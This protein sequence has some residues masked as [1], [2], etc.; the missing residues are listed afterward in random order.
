MAKLRK[1]V[2]D[3]ILNPVDLAA[4]MPMPA[5]ETVVNVDDSIRA[6]IARALPGLHIKSI[7]EIPSGRIHVVYRVTDYGNSAVFVSFAPRRLAWMFREDND[8][9]HA[10]ASLV[11]WINNDSQ[12]LPQ[13]YE[14]QSDDLIPVENDLTLPNDSSCIRSFVPRLLEHRLMRLASHTPYNLFTS[15]PGQALS[16]LPRSLTSMEYKSFQFQ[17][18]QLIRRISLLRSPTGRFGYAQHIVPPVPSE[19]NWIRHNAMVNTTGTSYPRWSDAFSAMFLNLT[20]DAEN[21]GINFSRQRCESTVARFKSFLDAVDEPRLLLLDA[22]SA[23]NTLVQTTP[24]TSEAGIKVTGLR[25]W[26]CGVFGDPL[27]TAAFTDGTN[28]DLWD[29]YYTSLG[30]DA[31]N[32]DYSGSPI[33]DRNHVFIRL[34]LYQIYH[35]LVTVV[36]AF[37]TRH[38]DSFDIQMQGRKK[39]MSS[40]RKLDEFDDQGK[41]IQ[42]PPFLEASSAK[43][44]KSGNTSQRCT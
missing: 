31:V 9:V 42:E 29:G 28:P 41:P 40:I 20:Y 10:E 25:E 33:V 36:K 19:T 18:G 6:V 8:A 32:A 34:L 22:G 26:S 14:I 15:P 5:A 12:Q 27:F 1:M 16:S 17:V 2:L 30:P 13:V 21:L 24:S 7:E 38:P 3:G 4:F 39:M 23:L 43:R 11:Q 37:V 44:F 35:G